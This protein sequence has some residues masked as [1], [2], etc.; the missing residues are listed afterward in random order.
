VTRAFR[1]HGYIELLRQ[2][3]VIGGID[4]RRNTGAQLR[5]TSFERAENQRTTEDVIA[6]PTTRPQ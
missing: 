2:L 3:A 6:A 5:R 1:L 4:G